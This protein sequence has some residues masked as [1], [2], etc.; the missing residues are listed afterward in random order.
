MEPDVTGIGAFYTI[1]GA[2]VAAIV[3]LWLLVRPRWMGLSGRTLWDW[4]GL[5]AVPSVVTLATVHVTS[6]AAMVERDRA[7]EAA[8]QQYFDRISQLV[9]SGDDANTGALDAVGRAQT[10]AILQLAEGPRAGRVL[11]FLAE[12]GRLSRYG[13]RYER[14]NLAGAEFKDLDLSGGDFEGATL[15]G[16]DLDHADLRGADLSGALGLG[17]DQLSEACLDVTTRLPPG[18]DAVTG[19]T[20]GCSGEAEDDD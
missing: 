6:N 20:P 4:I 14:L 12:I 15:W 19:P 11:V 9:L 5:L 7:T 3:L 16:A 18:F 8:L 17:A 2:A 13:G 10:L 1:L